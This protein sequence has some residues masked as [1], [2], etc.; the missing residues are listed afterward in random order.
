MLARDPSIRSPTWSLL[1]YALAVAGGFWLLAL[2]DAL[3]AAAT[4][5][6]ALV[7]LFGRAAAARVLVMAGVALLTSL[8]WFASYL[9]PD[10]YA[11]LMILAAATLAL[12]LGEP[13]PAASAWPD[14]ALPG[15]DHLPQLPPPARASRWPARRCC[16][17]RAGRSGAARLA[18]LGSAGAGGGR[19][20]CSRSAGS[21][22]ARPA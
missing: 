2:L 16:C 19:C 22:S 9:M 21:A 8:P 12:R 1:T 13:A 14:R 7:R 10:L 4:V 18:W 15:G 5:E 6:L 11:G 3:V 17:R 20:F